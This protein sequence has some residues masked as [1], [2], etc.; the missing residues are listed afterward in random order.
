M[1]SPATV[2]RK[3]ALITEEPPRRAPAARAM[4]AA[5]VQV[6]LQPNQGEAIV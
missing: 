2:G 3:V 6:P 5:R 1:T 4:Q